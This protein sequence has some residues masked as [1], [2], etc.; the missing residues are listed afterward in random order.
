MPDPPGANPFAAER[1]FRASA[2][3]P[4]RSAKSANGPFQLLNTK[5]LGTH[6]NHRTLCEFVALRQELQDIIVQHQSRDCGGQGGNWACHMVALKQQVSQLR[7][8]S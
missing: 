8:Q 2:A 6:Q 1:A 5:R 4:H 3:A 7:Q